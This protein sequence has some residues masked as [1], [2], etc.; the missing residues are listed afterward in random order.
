MCEREW[1]ALLEIAY[2]KKREVNGHV[3]MRE[4]EAVTVRMGCGKER[5]GAHC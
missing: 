2:V 1:G 5:E 4:G 3:E